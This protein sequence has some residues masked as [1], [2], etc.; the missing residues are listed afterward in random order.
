MKKT[1]LALSISTFSIGVAAGTIVTE[2]NY[3]TAM[4]DKGMAFEASNGAAQDWHHHRNAIALNKQ[5]APMMNRDTLYSFFMADAQSDFKIILPE[6]DGRYM[7][8]QVMNHNHETAYVF[9]GSGEHIV[10]ADETTDHVGF[11]VR[12]QIDASNP[13]DIK[14]ANSYQDEFQVEFLD[15]SYQPEIF[16]A[17]EW[18]KETFDKLHERYQKQAGELG[19]VGTMSDLQAN[20]IVTQEA[21]NRGVSVA[22]GLLPNAHAMYVQTDYNLDASKCYV[23]THEVPKLMDEELGFFSITMYDENIYIA[24]DEHSIITNSDIET[25]GDN[26]FTVHYGT[27]EICGNVVNLLHVPT[28]DFTT[29]M[30]VY[31]PNV[32]AV[33]QYQVGELVEVK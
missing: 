12:I 20:D 10:K 18:D 30:R 24:T 1:L 22:T 9:Y 23:A 2:E 26:T 13:K 3:S 6:T 17:S 27:P 19:I 4:F 14:L 5:P 7:S 8:I 28:D 21:R 31:L 29:T 11:W 16:K 25:N 15:P 32:E 33:E